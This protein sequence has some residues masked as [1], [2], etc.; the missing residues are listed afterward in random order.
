M[1]KYT[2]SYRSYVDL[3]VSVASTGASNVL[4]VKNANTF[5][6]SSHFTV[7]TGAVTAVV[8][9]LEG[10]LDQSKWF[11]LGEYT[12]TAA[13]LT[14]L[15]AMFHVIN[16]HVS[17]VRLNL[18]TFTKSGTANFNAKLSYQPFTFV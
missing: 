18:A 7:T 13:D 11:T 17:H 15:Q 1:D 6:I 12:Y 10:T 4:H 16:K 5:T 3:L 2:D 14:A 8:I 9:N